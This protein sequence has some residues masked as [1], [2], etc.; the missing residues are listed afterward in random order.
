M[1]FEEIFSLVFCGIVLF[2]MFSSVPKKWGMWLHEITERGSHEMEK[3]TVVLSNFFLV[4]LK[5]AVLI[6]GIYF[7]SKLL[8]T[9]GFFHTTVVIIGLLILYQLEKISN[10]LAELK[11]SNS[12]EIE[13]ED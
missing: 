2:F 8:K 1:T 10:Q 5:L 4:V 12:G 3:H 7:Y 11:H 6:V 9:H 13:N